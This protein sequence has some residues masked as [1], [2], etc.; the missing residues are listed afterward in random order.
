MMFQ[1]QVDSEILVEKEQT[2]QQ[3]K[4]TVE[5]LELKIRKLE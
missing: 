5:I 2:I 3:L 4:E 1:N